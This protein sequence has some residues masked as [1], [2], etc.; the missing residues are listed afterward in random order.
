MRFFCE[1]ET[2]VWAGLLAGIGK[3]FAVRTGAAAGLILSEHE[4]LLNGNGRGE[5]ICHRFS[6]PRRYHKNDVSHK[7]YGA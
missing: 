1:Q 4:V 5:F 6:R 3:V 2:A 7:P